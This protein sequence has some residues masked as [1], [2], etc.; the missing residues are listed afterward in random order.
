MAQ[1]VQVFCRFRPLNGVERGREE[2][3]ESADSGRGKSSFQFV[4]K[5]GEE[6]EERANEVLFK[7]DKWHE[8]HHFTFDRIFEP[9]AKQEEGEFLVRSA[10]PCCFS[11]H[12]L[13]RPPTAVYAEVGR[14][15]VDDLIK[16]FNATLFAYG[17]TGSGK[18]HTLLGPGGDPGIV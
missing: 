10:A 6:G 13:D 3:I 8:N 16:G 14:K 18:T 5:E 9:E 17:Q 1:S 2:E 4:A 7:P 11:L 12:R 15:L